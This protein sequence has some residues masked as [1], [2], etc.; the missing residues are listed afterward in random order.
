MFSVDV[1]LSIDLLFSLIGF[2][3]KFVL[4]CCSV[5][6]VIFGFIDD[7]LLTLWIGDVMLYVVCVL[8]DRGLIIS[9]WV[10]PWVIL[11]ILENSFPPLYQLF[12]TLNSLRAHTLFSYIVDCNTISET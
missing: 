6:L 3:F 5:L 11:E 4:F 7:M 8:E 12:C 2:D 10:T 1:A 9:F